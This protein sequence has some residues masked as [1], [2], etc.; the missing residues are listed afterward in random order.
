M[1]KSV[2]GTNWN[3]LK[4]KF[5]YVRLRYKVQKQDEKGDIT[6]KAEQICDND[7]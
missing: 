7:R 6:L 3:K 5:G 2:P 1:R 4:S